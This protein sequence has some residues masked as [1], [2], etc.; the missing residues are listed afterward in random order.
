ML[1]LLLDKPM[2]RASSLP[3][4]RHTLDLVYRTS[5]IVRVLSMD[6][7]AVLVLKLPRHLG[8]ENFTDILL[9]FPQ[10]GQA[11]VFD[12][13]VCR[14]KCA[15]NFYGTFDA[16]PNPNDVNRKIRAER[17]KYAVEL[18]PFATI[19]ASA[20][21]DRALAAFLIDC[22]PH[23]GVSGIEILV[24]YDNN[25]RENEKVRLQWY[26]G[27]NEATLE[28]KPIAEWVPQH[29][30]GSEVSLTWMSKQG[31]PFRGKLSNIREYFSEDNE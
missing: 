28:F 1:N 30:E 17:Y 31:K 3:E 16:F 26:N 15:I 14:G 10:D 19:H 23:A 9:Y 25:R 5:E 6:I 7:P 21:P 2:F 27:G 12:Y 22:N 24:D 20:C 18:L 4:H 8:H 11:S 13:T 29:G